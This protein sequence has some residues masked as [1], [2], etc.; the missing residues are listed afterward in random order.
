MF[1][2]FLFDFNNGV[3]VRVILMVF[4]FLFKRFVKNMLLEL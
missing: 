4:L 1:L 2:V 3:F